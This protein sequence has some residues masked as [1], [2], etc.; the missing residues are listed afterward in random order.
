MVVRALTLSW[1]H[2]ARKTETYPCN[3]SQNVRCQQVW[4]ISRYNKKT[5]DVIWLIREFSELIQKN[6]HKNLWGRGVITIDYLYRTMDWLMKHLYRMSIQADRTGMNSR[7]LAIVWSPN[8]LRFLSSI[9]SVLYTCTVA[10]LPCFSNKSCTKTLATLQVLL[11]MN[12]FRL[13]ND[14]FI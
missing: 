1:C 6:P 4:K 9:I 3:K 2:Q 11:C 5:A 12:N 10:V 7:N 8:I 13:K 14:V